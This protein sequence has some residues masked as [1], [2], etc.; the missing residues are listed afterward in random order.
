MIRRIYV[1]N[2]KCLVNFELPLQE[3][4]LL[5]GP[6][7]VGK[8]A[9]L[10]VASAL[11]QLLRGTAKVAS[12]EAFPPASRTRWHTR[13]LQ[14]FELEVALESDPLRYRLEVEHGRMAGQARI[15]LERL[16]AAGKPLFEFRQGEVHLFRDD[17]SPGPVFHADWSESALARVPP[18]HDNRRLSRF[19]AFVRGLT[20]CSFSPPGFR[21]ESS[22]EDPH[23]HRD[24]SN[25]ASWYRWMLQ[26]RPDCDSALQRALAE[27]V[28]GFA[29]MRL[30]QIGL[31]TRALIVALDHG[32]SP[33]ELWFHEL[34][35][36]QRAL[37]VLYA[38]LHFAK[39]KERLVGMS[40]PPPR[41]MAPP[42]TTTTPPWQAATT[43]TTTTT[44]TTMPLPE[45]FAP[46]RPGVSCVFLDEP[47]NYLA[48]AEIQPWLME[49]MDACGDGFQA[50]LCSHHPELIDYLG[51]EGGC[52]LQR[53][54]SGVTVVRPVSEMA[55]AEGL[56]LSE[57]GAR[58]W[59][60]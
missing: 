4:T 3:V 56:K 42:T 38:L 7:G 55:C 28:E 13:P 50:V 37:I 48:L 45:E 33:Y 34:S 39:A 25:F 60:R 1:D 29:G 8:T 23:L 26:E 2:Y 32:G 27:V 30:T 51:P 20:V 9:V 43:T 47:D 46:P 17:H 58:G 52:M 36:G 22:S 31:D 41:D 35:D 10:E 49:L 6:N 14:T 59:E 11:Q 12:N 18:R 54:Q 40:A 57:V 53:E 21:T 16:E 15:L 44:S 5:L 19:L 24:G